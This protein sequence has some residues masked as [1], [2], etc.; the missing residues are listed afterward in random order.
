M[1][2]SSLPI[3]RVWRGR[4]QAGRPRA[5]HPFWRSPRARNNGSPGCAYYGM[6]LCFMP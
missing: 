1:P 2:T 6:A 3:L 5:D 4:Y